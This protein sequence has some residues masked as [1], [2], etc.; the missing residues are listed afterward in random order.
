MAV[1]SNRGSLKQ[2]VRSDSNSN[3]KINFVVYC[4]L[5][6]KYDCLQHANNCISSCPSYGSTHLCMPRAQCVC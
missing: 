6:T 5:K 4:S 2:S 3:R 1:T